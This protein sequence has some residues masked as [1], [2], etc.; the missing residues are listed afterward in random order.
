MSVRIPG[1]G[2]TDGIPSVRRRFSI[3]QDDE[4]ASY[5]FEKRL[6]LAFASLKRWII[7]NF[8]RDLVRDHS[9][10]PE[11][12]QFC[13]KPATPGPGTDAIPSLCQDSYAHAFALAASA[14]TTISGATLLR[15]PS[16]EPRRLDRRGSAVPLV[17]VTAPA[18]NQSLIDAGASLD[19]ANKCVECHGPAGEGDPNPAP[20][21]E[22]DVLHPWIQ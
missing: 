14:A 13:F 7:L 11:K 3:A 4:A 8:R 17:S 20:S 1:D 10:Q 18:A 22:E 19:A 12:Y 9:S 5:L 15:A 21:L 2:A 16:S 6:H